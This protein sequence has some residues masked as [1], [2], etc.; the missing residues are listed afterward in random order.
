VLHS[1]IANYNYKQY[2]EFEDFGQATLQADNG[3]SGYFRVDWFTPNGLGSWGDGRTV[4]L[5]TDGYI[6]LRKYL[7]VARTK[8]GTSVLVN[9]EGESHHPVAGTVGFPFFGRLIRTAWTTPT[10]PI[11]RSFSSRPSNWHRRPDP[12]GQ[13]GIGALHPR[14]AMKPPSTG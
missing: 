6:E 5:G 12:G 10:R 1:A 8:E 13:A 9:H 4:I 3:A 2:P 7:D 14:I 11:P